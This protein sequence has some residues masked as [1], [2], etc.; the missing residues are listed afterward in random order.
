MKPIHAIQSRIVRLAARARAEG[1][2]SAVAVLVHTMTAHRDPEAIPALI[3]LLD[4]PDH[5]VGSVE[6]ALVRYGEAA[7]E[8]LKAYAATSD[9]AEATATLLLS[10]IAYRARL[11]QL[12]C[13]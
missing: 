4:L 10:R 2:S 3:G 7:E 12:G 6:R 1:S 8:S 5:R 11:R 13:F 9:V